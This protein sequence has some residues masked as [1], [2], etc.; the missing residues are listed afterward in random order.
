MNLTILSD[1]PQLLVQHF[2]ISSAGLYQ[3]VQ[4]DI[5]EPVLC[6][7]TYYIH[8]IMFDL[9]M[10]YLYST[11]SWVTL[12]A[13]PPPPAVLYAQFQLAH[14]QPLLYGDGRD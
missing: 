14:Q 7:C 9:M 12:L 1:N 2:L 3:S 10:Q 13:I 8:I 5:V 6:Y 11:L 4:T